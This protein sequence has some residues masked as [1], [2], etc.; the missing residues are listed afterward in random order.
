M[1][2]FFALYNRSKEKKNSL[3][4]CTNIVSQLDSHVRYA[5]LYFPAES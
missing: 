4:Y 5:Q 1:F 3:L 2:V